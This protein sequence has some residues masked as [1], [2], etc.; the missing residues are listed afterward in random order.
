[1]LWIYQLSLHLIFCIQTISVETSAVL[2]TELYVNIYAF[3]T[4]FA[5]V[6]EERHEGL[7]RFSITV[8][9][10]WMEGF[11]KTFSRIFVSLELLK[12]QQHGCGRNNFILR[13][14]TQKK[15]SRFVCSH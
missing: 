6:G 13:Q 10:L 14:Y 15:H 8:L 11:L 5:D 3:I 12:K 9:F 4:K 1:M 7:T 2:E